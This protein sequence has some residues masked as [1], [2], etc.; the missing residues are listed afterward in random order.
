ME[1]RPLTAMGCMYGRHTAKLELNWISE[2]PIV[3]AKLHYFLFVVLSV[4]VFSGLQ[5]YCDF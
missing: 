3:L 4:I 5:L 1:T 2:I